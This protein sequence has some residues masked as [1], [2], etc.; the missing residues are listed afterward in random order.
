MR[1]ERDDVGNEVDEDEGAS[2]APCCS[3]CSGDSSD[4][5]PPADDSDAAGRAEYLFNVSSFVMTVV[6]VFAVFGG[7]ILAKPFWMA[8]YERHAFLNKTLLLGLIVLE[9]GI[10]MKLYAVLLKFRIQPLSTDVPDTRADWFLKIGTITFSAAA[11][12]RIVMGMIQA[13]RLMAIPRIGRALDALT[14][15]ADG[16]VIQSFGMGAFFL[17]LAIFSLVHLLHSKYSRL[18]DEEP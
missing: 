13:R 9:V 6:A 8:L 18:A 3:C 14:I 17:L 16:L 1:D 11:A 2:G 12:M 4:G 10:L 5:A 15:E 7:F